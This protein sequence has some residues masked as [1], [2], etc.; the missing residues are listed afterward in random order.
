MSFTVA[1]VMVGLLEVQGARPFPSLPDLFFLLA[2]PLFAGGLL[3][4]SRAGFREGRR[5]TFIDAGII[6]IAATLFA[7]VLITSKYIADPDLS[8]AAAIVA[9]AYPLADV[10]LVAVATQFLLSTGWRPIALRLLA[11]GLALILAGDVVFSVQ[12]LYTSAGDE[13]LADALLL[14]GVLVLGLAGLHP[15]M[16]ALTARTSEATLPSYSVRRVVILYLI[17]LLPVVVLTAQ[18][19][20]GNVD[21]VWITLL[22]LA[23]IAALV[24]TRFVDLVGRTL[25][26]A[27][28]EAALSRFG[29]DLL[30]RTGHD[31]LV[32]PPSGRPTTSF[33]EGPRRWSRPGRTRSTRVACSRRGSWSTARWS[34]PWSPTSA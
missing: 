29:S 4:A 27:E 31:E 2:Y 12:G 21:Y 11:V 22:A 28:R 15:S 26:A 17:S 24:V 5:G 30:F 8:L 32:A 19:L 9:S 16:T 10:L 34:A 1:D 7:L 33:P 20:T 6:T 3:V 23:A 13:T 18:A 14:G 25:R